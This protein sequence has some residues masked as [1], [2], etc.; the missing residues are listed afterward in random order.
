MSGSMSAVE[1]SQASFA[2]MSDN[3]FRSLVQQW[4]AA[5]VVGHYAELKGRGG[6]GDEEVGFDMRVA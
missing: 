5:H 4:L 3:D 1:T 2:S 6:P